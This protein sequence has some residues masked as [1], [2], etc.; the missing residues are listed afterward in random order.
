MKRNQLKQ[1]IVVMLEK[2]LPYCHSREATNEELAEQILRE[3][4][5]IT[6]EE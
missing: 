2:A 3:I 4:D 1:R 6:L 5:K